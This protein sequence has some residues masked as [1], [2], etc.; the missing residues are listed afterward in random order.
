MNEYISIDEINKRFD[1]E[2][3]LLEDPQTSERM[4]VLGG[5]LL[6]HSKDR[7]E[8]D[9]NSVRFQGTRF[10]VLFTGKMPEDMVFAL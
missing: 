2:W 10:A 3:V 1:S 7:A 9:R 5:K 8:F 6:Y 4:E